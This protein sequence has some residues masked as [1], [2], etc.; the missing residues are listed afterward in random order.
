MKTLRTVLLRATSALL[1]LAAGCAPSPRYKPELPEDLGNDG[2]LVG[3][4]LGIGRLAH[5]SLHKDVLIND[6]KRGQLVNGMFAIALS[7]GEYTFSGLYSESYGGSNTFNGVTVTTKNTVSLPVKKKFT[8]RAKEVTNLGLLVLYPDPRDKPD[9]KDGKFLQFVVDNTADMKQYVKSAYPALAAKINLEATTLVPGTTMND[10]QLQALRRELLAT[11]AKRV[12]DDARYLV[13][14]LGAL[15]EVQPDRDGKPTGMKLLDLPTTSSP[16]SISPSFVKDRTAILTN[17]NRLFVVQNGRATEKRPPE[18]LRAGKIFAVGTSALVIVDDHFEIYLSND[19]GDQW[20]AQTGFATKE[21][22]SA[23]VAVG[24]NGYYAYTVNPPALLFSEHGKTEFARFE[25]PGDLKTFG[26]LNE[27]PAG[28]FAEQQITFYKET[29]KRPF[30]FRP[31]GKPAWEKLFMPAPNCDYIKF[32]DGQ[33]NHLSTAC[34]D[35]AVGFGGPT[36]AYVSKDRGNT[37]QKI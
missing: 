11:A 9:A 12:G 3:E 28:L 5:W 15:A 30:Y 2:L 16:A 18:R 8:V 13:A 31:S 32:Q 1:V 26:M 23:R 24:R 7:P 14:G 37:W 17:N 4:V 6:R 19:N 33:G 21:T 25:L 36:T 10:K 22:V 27:T 35:R 29:E 20:H 34:S